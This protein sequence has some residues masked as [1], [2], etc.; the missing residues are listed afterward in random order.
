MSTP[1]KG[2]ECLTKTS[3]ARR[4]GEEFLLGQEY[5]QPWK[6][7]V[8]TATQQQVVGIIFYIPARKN[9]SFTV[10][11]PIPLNIPGAWRIMLV[12]RHLPL[13]FSFRPPDLV[14]LEWKRA[15]IQSATSWRK[16]IQSVQT[17]RSW[18]GRSARDK[19]QWGQNLGP[20]SDQTLVSSSKY[21][22]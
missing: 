18:Y 4:T 14:N 10:Y 2:P 8:K 22:Q 19:A 5:R 21:S 11:T 16:G 15:F 9:T 13:A 7:D 1:C 3:Y 20:Q 12:A 6:M 17:S